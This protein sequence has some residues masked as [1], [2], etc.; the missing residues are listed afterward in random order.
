MTCSA[1]KDRSC[2]EH[3]LIIEATVK[4]RSLAFTV[5]SFQV[6]LSYMPLPSFDERG[7]LPEGV[8]PASLEEVL[9]RFGHDTPQRQLVAARLAHIYELAQGTGKLERFV[10]FGSFVTAKPEPNDVDI[11]LVMRDDFGEEDYE[12][13]VFPVFDHLRA[14][15]E[16]GASLFVIRPAF[17]I[18]ES[19]DE[20]IEHWQ[21]KRDSK[22]R[23]IVEVV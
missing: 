3:A 1:S 2:V 11:I 5:A 12:P 23:G 18:G 8:H 14:Q 6:L 20:F 10:V 15:R 21:I 13:D 7:D 22:R 4:V 9:V 19:V 16:L 17:I